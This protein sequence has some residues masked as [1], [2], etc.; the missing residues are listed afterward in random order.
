MCQGQTYTRGFRFKMVEQKDRRSYPPARAPKSQLVVEQP[1]T[2]GH[3]NPPKKDTLRPKTKKLQ[4]DGRRETHGEV[5]SDTHQV[6]DLQTGE[7]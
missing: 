6:S 3:W 7:Q 5:K 1:L 2:G 4:Q